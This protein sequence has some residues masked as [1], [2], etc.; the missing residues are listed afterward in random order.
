MGSRSGLRAFLFALGLVL[1]GILGDVAWRHGLWGLLTGAMLAAF[2][3]AALIG[4]EVAERRAPKVAVAAPEPGSAFALRLL[5]DALPT[6][7]V[8]IEGSSA[9]AL[10]RAGRRL[11]ATDD[12]IV[13]TP[14]ALLDADAAYF[15]FEGRRWR[16][17]RVEMR[18][19]GGPAALAALIDIEQEERAA[20]ARAGAELIQIL[21]HELLNGLS[22]IVSLAESG[23]AAADDPVL[24]REILGTLARRA[25]GLQRFT[26]SYRALARL[27]APAIRPVRLADLAFDLSRLFAGRWP[28][29]TLEVDVPEDLA[30]PLDRDQIN[31]AVWALLQNAAEAAPADK[32]AAVCLRIQRAGA[33]LAV[34]VQDNG[35]G[36]P[37]D[38]TRNIFRPFHT[39]KP[40]GSG[41]GL[42]LARQVATA[43]G[44]GLT[45]EPG[46]ATIFRLWLPA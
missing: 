33:G 42:S 30:W 39:S 11:F 16:I 24:L 10:N 7:L 36:I 27:P 21:G 41:I 8:A 26:A 6:P 9:R 14:A 23:L 18:E 44:G 46:V 20:E 1:C 13:P 35:P 43:H 32:D 29:V 38:A 40:D 12:R 25:D 17:D 45:L 5:L 2:W 37:P 19:T 34:D 4:W 3:L 28:K 22:P 15:G 31:Q